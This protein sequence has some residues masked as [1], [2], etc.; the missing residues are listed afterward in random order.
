MSFSFNE[1][2]RDSVDVL[3][4]NVLNI[5][6]RIQMSLLRPLGSIATTITSMM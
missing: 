1:G 4:T 2:K 3:A 5:E 6:Y